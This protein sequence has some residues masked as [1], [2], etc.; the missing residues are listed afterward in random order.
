MQGMDFTDRRILVAFADDQYCFR[1]VAHLR[2]DMASYIVVPFVQVQHA[3]DMQVVTRGPFHHLLMTSTDSL[4][5]LMSSIRSRIPSMIT[6][7]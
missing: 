3:M 2:T 5:L 1:L 6:S 4:V 7:P